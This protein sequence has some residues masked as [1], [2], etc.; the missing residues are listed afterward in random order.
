MGFWFL[1]IVFSTIIV[2]L[3]KSDA[4]FDDP[5][6]LLLIAALAALLPAIREVAI[7][8]LSVLRYE[9]KE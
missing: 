5:G 8:V 1:R 6:S 9:K 3:V 4:R 2:A 7:E